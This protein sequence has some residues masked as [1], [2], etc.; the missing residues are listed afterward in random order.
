MTRW[1]SQHESTYNATEKY[2][3]AFRENC[4]NTRIVSNQTGIEDHC[5]LTRTQKETIG[6]VV[7]TFGRWAMILSPAKSTTFYVSDKM[8]DNSMFNNLY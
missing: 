5:F 7:S 8:V 6:G 4:T 3:T 2:A 1:Q